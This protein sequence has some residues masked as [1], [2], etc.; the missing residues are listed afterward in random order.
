MK[1]WNLFKKHDAMLFWPGHSVSFM[2]DSLYNTS[3]LWYAMDLEK[4]VNMR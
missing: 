3:Q 4:R 1:K 2:G